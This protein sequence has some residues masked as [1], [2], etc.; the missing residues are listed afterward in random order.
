MAEWPVLRWRTVSGGE[1]RPIRIG[2]LIEI[3][4]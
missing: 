2:S 4:V 3:S 1:K